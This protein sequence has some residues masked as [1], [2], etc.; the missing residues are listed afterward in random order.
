MIILHQEKCFGTSMKLQKCFPS[1]DF[2][3][4]LTFSVFCGKYILQSEVY[5]KIY[6][7]FCQNT[8]WKYKLNMLLKP[9]NQKKKDKSIF[10]F[11]KLYD[12]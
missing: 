6:L 8:A 3:A 9:R 2:I 4:R 7:S 12:H 5:I 11:Y 1:G 10:F